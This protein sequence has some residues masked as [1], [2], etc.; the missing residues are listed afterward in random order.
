MLVVKREGNQL[1]SVLSKP[2]NA[3]DRSNISHACDM[4]A[5]WQAITGCG[6][7]GSCWWHPH[8]KDSK[9]HWPLG[10]T[11]SLLWKMTT[12]IVDLPN[13]QMV[14]FHS[15]VNVYKRV[16]RR[17]GLS[18]GW[19]TGKTWNVAQKLPTDC[20]A[21]AGPLCRSSQ[22]TRPVVGFSPG[23]LRVRSWNMCQVHSHIR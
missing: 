18:L 10:M 9:V 19:E 15:Y 22:T 5:A 2:Q 6:R 4:R 3:Q 14:I 13:L 8:Q 12:E 1:H 23:C 11:I 17:F 21:V 16:H 7:S 20:F